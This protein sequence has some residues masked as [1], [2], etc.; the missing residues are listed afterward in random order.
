MFLSNAGF[1][2][3]KLEITSFNTNF[4]VIFQE[5]EMFYQDNLRNRQ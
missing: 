1:D 2:E 3:G 4:G 5:L